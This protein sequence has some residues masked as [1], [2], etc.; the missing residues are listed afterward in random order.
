MN[1]T[2]A[3]IDQ[4]VPL[5]GMLGYLNFGG[6][7]PDARFEKQL[8][9]VYGLLAER[10]AAEP[11]Q[12]LHELLR[13]K[14]DALQAAG[15]GAFRDTAQARAVLALTFDHVLPAYRQHH[16]DLLFHLSDRDLFQPFFLTR[17]FEAVLLQG[18]PW[19]EQERIVAGAVAH[20]NDYVGYR[21]VAV[22]ENRPRGEPYDHERVRPIPLYIRGAGVAVGRY[23]GLISRALDLLAAT[24]PAILAEAGL[25][26]DLLDELALD[27]R[28]YDQGH[29][30]NRR[31]NY[32]FGEWDPHHLDSQG[33]FRR[34]VARQ[35]T[36][37]ALAERAE[38]PGVDRQEA[39]FESAAVFA[40][41]LL[42]AVGTTGPSPTAY[43]SSVTLAT[44][45]PRVAGYRDTFYARLLETIHGPHGDR[46][47]QEAEATHQPFGGARQYLNQYLARH[48]AA[49]LQ[50]RHL[51][52]L[53][54][55]MGYPDAS[56]Q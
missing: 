44:L 3:D 53:F 47:R 2:F 42:M 19:D 1:P 22:L 25:D 55:E 33:R 4:A 34:Y 14:L 43:D 48:R 49:Q 36:L 28:A 9:E 12:A 21:P 10:G 7:K 38:R 18:S 45:M 13:W 51:A 35:V 31:P 24:D 27:P 54:A 50:Q 8:N 46:L 11:W 15:A 29:P 5:Q 56:R 20:L 17:V 30:V 39:L 37:D 16:A 32:I 26:L 52:V 6:G 40:G 41:T 23:H